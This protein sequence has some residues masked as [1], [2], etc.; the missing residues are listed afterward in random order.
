MSQRETRQDAINWLLNYQWLGRGTLGSGRGVE[1]WKGAAGL[2]VDDAEGGDGELDWPGLNG[3]K[4][5]VSCQTGRNELDATYGYHAVRGT[6]GVLGVQ[7]Q[8]A[9]EVSSGANSGLVDRTRVRK[10]HMSLKRVR[11]GLSTTVNVG[12]ALACRLG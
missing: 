11:G 12:I 1:G 8:V 9:E 7:R 10:V 6:Q 3:Y 5:G 4:R 2:P